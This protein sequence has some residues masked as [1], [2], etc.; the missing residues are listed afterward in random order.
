MSPER[1]KNSFPIGPIYVSKP[2]R[3]KGL[4]YFSRRA[5][6]A[7]GQTQDVVFRLPLNSGDMRLRQ[8]H[9]GA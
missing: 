6:L 7:G 1:R 2:G 5:L 4:K 9:H 8:G 3:R